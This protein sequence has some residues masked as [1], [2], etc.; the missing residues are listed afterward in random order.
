MASSDHEGPRGGGLHFGQ[1]KYRARRLAVLVVAVI[2][3]VAALVAVD[4]SGGG[5]HGAPGEGRLAAP[6]TGRATTSSTAAGGQTTTSQPMINLTSNG[7][8]GVTSAAIMAENSKPGTTAW[9]ITNQPATGTIDGFADTTY[10]TVG[11]TVGIYVS[12]SAPIFVVHA[13]RMGWY[14]GAGA[15]EVWTSAPTPG[16]HQPACPVDHRTNTVSCANWAKTLT[17]PI[18]ADF[19][20]GDYM[21]KLVGSDGEQSYILLT[22]WDPTSTSTYLVM[23]R[24]L[25]EAGWNTY[26]GYDFYQGTGPCILG[27]TGSYPPCN[28]ARVVSFDRPAAPG[29]IASDF[30]SNEFPLVE[31]MEKDGLDVSY[32][33]DV[34][35][36]A[37][38]AILAE[39]RTVLSLGHDETWTY[40]EREGAQAALQHGVNFLLG[41]ATMVRHARLRSSALGPDQEVVDY[42]DST[43][44]PLYRT[45]TDPMDVTGN[46]WTSPPANWSEI[47]FTGEVYSG[48]LDG[49]DSVPF[50][51]SDAAAWVFQG[52]GLRDG[53][54]IPGVIES[55]IDHLA[56]GGGS[57]ANIQV[58]GHSPVPLTEAF[59]GQ[60]KWGGKTYSD[61]T[62]YTNPQSGAGVIDTG[63][64]NWI[65]ALASCTPGQPGCGAAEVIA[66]TQ[67]ILRVFGEGPAGHTEPSTANWTSITPA[68]S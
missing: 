47:P 8:D 43:E 37:H 16:V 12:T 25:T 50:V 67:N 54:S 24:S 3:V 22:V 46:T 38:P 20:Q 68:G 61:M 55:D 49:A 34:T 32:C 13:Y 21:L 19:V 14:G 28:R 62:Y 57:P 15:R 41:A 23:A 51:V 17:M 33:T 63:T 27:Q 45:G 56:P 36:D 65:Y 42:R 66:I 10:A 31:L 44:D 9:R 52:T 29:Y 1:A 59:T 53:S 4:L 18:T 64:T 39:H 30:L 40:R 2:V 48:Y 58:L 35:A 7:P 6:E 26:G 11:Q 60:G 5:G